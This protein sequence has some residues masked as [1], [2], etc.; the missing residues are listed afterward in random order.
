MPVHDEIRYRILKLLEADPSLT[1]RKLAEYD[2][3][4]AD[5]EALRRKWPWTTRCT[6]LAPAEF[7]RA[8]FDVRRISQQERS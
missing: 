4:K 6:R 3:L 7:L 2:A 5:I 1:Q 8:T